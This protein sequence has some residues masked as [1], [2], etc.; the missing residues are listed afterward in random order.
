MSFNVTRGHAYQSISSAMGNMTAPILPMKSTAANTRAIMIVSR[1]KL[2][3]A[4]L[5]RGNATAR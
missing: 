3:R 4:S 1:A 2:A 5:K